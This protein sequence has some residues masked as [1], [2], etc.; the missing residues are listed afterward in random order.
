MYNPFFN[1]GLK[2]VGK[3]I[4]PSREEL[5]GN[6]QQ[7]PQLLAFGSHSDYQP[8]PFCAL[9]QRGSKQKVALRQRQ[10]WRWLTGQY[11]PIRLDNICLGVD[12]QVWQI[13][14][15]HHRGLA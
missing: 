6:L 1:I 10:T 14:I 15:V 8:M 11:L 5:V 4:A 13:G 9:S 3:G 12:L 2:G 7:V